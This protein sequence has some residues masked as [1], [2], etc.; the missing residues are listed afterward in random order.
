MTS[1]DG[2]LQKATLFHRAFLKLNFLGGFLWFSRSKPWFDFMIL[3]T[4]RSRLITKAFLFLYLFL[5]VFL[6][7]LFLLVTGPLFT[8]F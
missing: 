1:A 7:S 2:D 4:K 3:S 5:H 6:F 8:F